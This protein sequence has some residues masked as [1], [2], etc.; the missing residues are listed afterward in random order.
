MNIFKSTTLTWQQLGLIK[1]A[2]IFIG[3]AI[4]SYWPA[5]FAPYA[6]PLFLLGLAMSIYPAI[7]WFRNK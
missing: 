5:V 3:I 4:G 2:V 1:W 7:V 6:I